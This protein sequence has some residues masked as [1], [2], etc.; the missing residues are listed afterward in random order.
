M[1]GTRL[2]R[3]P[4]SICAATFV[5]LAPASALAASEGNAL[6][7]MLWQALNLVIVLGVLIYFGRKPAL[8]YFATRR[9]DIKRDLDTAAELL[10]AAEHRNAEIQRKLA[11]LSSEVEETRETSRRRADEECERI[12]AEA[13]KAAERIRTDAHAAAEQELARARRELRAEAADLA[14]RLAGDLLRQ[15]VGDS[16]R[17]RLLDEFITRV[18]SGPGAA[19]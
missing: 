14:V 1:R 18:E 16:D 2:A 12:L 10:A 7:E 6:T 11:D 15:N 19:A 9:A 4:A 8:E 17:E 13:R 5:T 3:L